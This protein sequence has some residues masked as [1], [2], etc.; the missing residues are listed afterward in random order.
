MRRPWSVW[1][2]ESHPSV[3]KSDSC[4]EGSARPSRSVERSRGAKKSLS[5]TSQLLQGWRHP[6]S[7][8]R[9]WRIAG[10]SLNGRERYGKPS[11]VKFSVSL[12]G[13]TSLVRPHSMSAAISF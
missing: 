6:P 13:E 9:V 7:Q 5:L 12:S 10:P 11:N 2:Y 8:G 4:L 1:T 3:D